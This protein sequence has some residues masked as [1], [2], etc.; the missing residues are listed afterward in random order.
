M[1]DHGLDMLSVRARA[2]RR[3]F[4]RVHVA[5]VIALGAFL[6]HSPVLLSADA[7]DLPAGT[8]ARDTIQAGGILIASPS[9][10]N[11]SGVKRV[12]EKCTTWTG[13]A[14]EMILWVNGVIIREGALGRSVDAGHVRM[15]ALLWSGWIQVCEASDKVTYAGSRGE[16]TVTAVE[17]S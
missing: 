7:A 4:R 11:F 6:V 9:F 13:S 16:A 1:G 5:V 8:S 15:R 3:S 10:T 2:E 12:E 17:P 14:S